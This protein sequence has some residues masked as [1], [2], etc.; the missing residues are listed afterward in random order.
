M[1]SDSFQIGL[2]AARVNANMSQAEVAEKLHVSN[3]TVCNWE[4]GKATPSFATVNSL[5]D[6]YKIP[7]DFIFIPKRTTLS[8]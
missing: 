6:L 7:V 3:K 4:N 1:N 8:E 5:S 2:A